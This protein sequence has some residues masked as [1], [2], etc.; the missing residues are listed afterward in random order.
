MKNKKQRNKTAKGST[1]RFPGNVLTPVAKFLKANLKKLE[2]RKKEITKEDPFKNSARLVDNASPDADA[3]EQF[4]HARTTA[5]REQID[6]KII[7]TRKALTRIKIGKYGICEDCGK[8]IDTDR[9]MAYPE[10]T[11]C[12]EDQA[13]REK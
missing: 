1:I 3:E 13:R 12:A 10:A 5:I 9:L 4:S 6:R 8:M 11:L 2:F 7:Q